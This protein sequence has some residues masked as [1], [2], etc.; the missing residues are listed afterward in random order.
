[1]IARVYSRL[2]HRRDDNERELI[3][4]W[5]AAGC[6]V[7]QQPPGQGFD[8]V[9]VAPLRRQTRCQTL[10]RRGQKRGARLEADR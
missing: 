6:I 10:H 3:D 4:F 7:Y 2:A 1:M 8:L 9:V 5:R